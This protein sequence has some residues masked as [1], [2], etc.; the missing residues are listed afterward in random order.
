MPPGGGGGGGGGGLSLLGMVI[1]E[2]AQFHIGGVENGSTR[3]SKG[4]PGKKGGHT[5]WWERRSAEEGM[6]KEGRSENQKGRKNRKVRRNFVGKEGGS[7]RERLHYP[8]LAT[9]IS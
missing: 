3:T 9:T 8:H 2:E 7:E 5:G 6:V 1:Y 4:V